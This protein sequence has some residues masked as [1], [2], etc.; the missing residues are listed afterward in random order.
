VY[1]AGLVL[2]LS[3]SVQTISPRY[4]LKPSGSHSPETQG[5]EAN[6]HI[7][8]SCAPFNAVA[9]HFDKVL[10][11]FR[12]LINSC[13][14]AKSAGMSHQMDGHELFRT[15]AWP[16]TP[17]S[18]R[19]SSISTTSPNSTLWQTSPD[20][21]A[22]YSLPPSSS[23]QMLA[24][25]DPT[26]SVNMNNDMSRAA[27]SNYYP[28]QTIVDPTYIGWPA[29]LP[30]DASSYSFVSKSSSRSGYG[31]IDSG[32]EHYKPYMQNFWATEPF[33]SGQQMGIQGNVSTSSQYG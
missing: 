32:F 7:L 25:S 12:A 2:A 24:G 26:T 3:L 23:Y 30:N 27:I 10:K 11:Y 13:E 22:M 1:H 4:S 29:A 20:M 17:S 28:Q 31:S 21:P 6:M 8:S 18:W 16:A 9:A 14:E 33:N 15:P 19:N 5:L